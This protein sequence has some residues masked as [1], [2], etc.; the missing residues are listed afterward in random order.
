[1]K[2][3]WG[4]VAGLLILLPGLFAF[5]EQQPAQPPAAGPKYDLLLR[6]G[7]VIDA[8][9]KLS[10]A[11]RG[12]R[13]GKIAAVDAKLNPADA[14]KTVDASGLHASRPV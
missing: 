1:M 4:L 9:N 14:L 12:D 10:A 13:N 3:R 6:G 5:R 8:R 11:R 2:T 7:H